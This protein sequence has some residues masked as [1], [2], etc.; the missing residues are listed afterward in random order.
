MHL[1][2]VSRTSVAQSEM[3]GESFLIVHRELALEIFGNE[4]DE[5]FTSQFAF[6]DFGSTFG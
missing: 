2:Q 5:F 3:L 4:L 1:L 6:F